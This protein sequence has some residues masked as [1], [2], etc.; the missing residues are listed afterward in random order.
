MKML[1]NEPP[2]PQP[3]AVR[4]KGR[5]LCNSVLQKNG[6][7]WRGTW[8]LG[9]KVFSKGEGLWSVADEEEAD[10]NSGESGTVRCHRV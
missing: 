9:T 1:G 2:L 4:L 7:R 10:G 6:S 3:H 5:W 8:G